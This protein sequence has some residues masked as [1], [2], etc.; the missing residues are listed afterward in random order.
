MKVTLRIVGGLL[1]A[2]GLA[3]ML[4]ETLGFPLLIYYGDA[5][6][7][8]LGILGAMLGVALITM[9]ALMGNLQSYNPLHLYVQFMD[10]FNDI[11][12]YGVGWFTTV[13]VVVVFA[14]VLLRYV[15]GQSYLALQDMSWYVFGIVYLVGAAYTLRHDR[16]VR[17]D[18]LYINFSPRGRVWIN[19][20]GGIF[21]LIPFCL[22]GLYVS[23]S[24]TTQSFASQ[25]ISPDPGGLAARYLAKAMVPLGF[26]LLTLQGLSLV[27][28]NILQLMG[29]LPIDT[30]ESGNL[31]LE[32]EGTGAH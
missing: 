32:I 23:W 26:I 11:L 13:M 12:G 15:Y 22:L 17:V 30:D 18:I 25:E 10:T 21:F 24:F 14:N 4:S 19:L 2:V 3:A 7:G 20:L 8:I 31:P 28:R 29:S 6:G 1:V 5:V 9:A 16:H 27:F